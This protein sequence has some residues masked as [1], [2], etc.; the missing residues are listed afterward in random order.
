[1]EIGC[2]DPKSGTLFVQKNGGA[3]GALGI[4]ILLKRGD[5]TPTPPQFFTTTD[6][7][8]LIPPY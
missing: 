1:M 5:Q 2:L 7:I 3:G 4:A 6:D 8:T